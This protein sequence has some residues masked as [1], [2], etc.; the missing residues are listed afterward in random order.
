M[1]QRLWDHTDDMGEQP[2]QKI[3]YHET[4]S[5]LHHQELFLHFHN[6]RRNERM[7]KID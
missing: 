6:M 4:D 1:T 5:R 7:N 2:L 3:D